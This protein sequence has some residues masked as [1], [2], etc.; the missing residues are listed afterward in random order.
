MSY[1]EDTTGRG[2]ALA[3]WIAAAT[4]LGFFVGMGVGA[5]LS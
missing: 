5:W 1:D 3:L 2:L 4:L